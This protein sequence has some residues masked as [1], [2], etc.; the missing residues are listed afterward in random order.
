MVAMVRLLL[1]FLDRVHR[2]MMGQPT[3]DLRDFRVTY[4]TD[5]VQVL[6]EAIHG[7]EDRYVWCVAIENWACTSHMGILP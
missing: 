3:E 5:V 2:C 7:L 6:K 4:D 1:W